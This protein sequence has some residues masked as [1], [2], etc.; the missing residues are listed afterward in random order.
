MSDLSTLIKQIEQLSP[1]SR[2]SLAQYI[3]Y[4]QWHE[5]QGKT[6]EITGWSFSFIEAYTEATSH[7][8]D[9]PAGMD[10]KM[11]SAM[12]GGQN[13]PALWAHPPVVGQAIIEYHV[14]IPPQI[15]ETRLK[16]A[17][18]I[19]D[20]A[21]IA[22]NNLVA[23]GIKVNGIRVWGQQTNDLSWQ[24]A[25]IPLDLAAGDIARIEFTTEAL[26][27]HEWTWAVWGNPELLGKISRANVGLPTG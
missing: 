3:E 11:A 4:L 26:G 1:E 13:R 20:G 2:L 27:S 6:R 15:A 12:V 19:R 21:E 9:D 25:K 16:V 14:P 5:A 18:G 22:Q 10:I 24:K 23:F 8:S 17:I 7:A